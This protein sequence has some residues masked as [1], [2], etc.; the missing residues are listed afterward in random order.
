MAYPL[1]LTA[2]SAINL[3]TT[4]HLRAGATLW[5]FR[6]KGGSFFTKDFEV[7]NTVT[8]QLLQPH[9][10]YRVLDLDNDASMESAKEVCKAIV[11]LESTI[12]DIKITR[13]LI[14]GQYEPIGSD[15]DKLITDQQLNQ[16]N[17]SSWGQIIGRP[18]AFAP[19][20]HLHLDEQ[21]YGFGH[22]TYLIDEIKNLIGSQ[23]KQGFGTIYQYID[24]LFLEK[25]NDILNQL[26]GIELTINNV[27]VARRFEKGQIIMLYVSTH[28]AD[29]FGYGTWQQITNTFLYGV[30]IAAQLG[31]TFKIGSGVD[32]TATK[33]YFWWL[34]D[35]EDVIPPGGGGEE[36]VGN[37]LLMAT[38]ANTIP[39]N[40]LPILKK[41]SIWLGIIGYNA[42]SGIEFGRHSRAHYSDPYGVIPFQDLVYFQNSLSHP[43]QIDYSHLFKI[44]VSYTNSISPTLG[45]ILNKWK[46]NNFTNFVNVNQDIS[47]TFTHNPMHAH[48]LS[49]ISFNDLW[50]DEPIEKVVRTAVVIPTTICIN[51]KTAFAYLA[52]KGNQIY[53]SSPFDL[54]ALGTGINAE[55]FK[56]LYPSL[57]QCD[58]GNSYEYIICRIDNKWQLIKYRGVAETRDYRRYE[59]SNPNSATYL[60]SIKHSLGWFRI[61]RGM[62]PTDYSQSFI[63]YNGQTISVEKLQ[64]S[65]GNY[66]YRTN[67]G[68]KTPVNSFIAS[69]GMLNP[70]EYTYVKPALVR[71]SSTSPYN[72]EYD[73]VV[74]CATASAWSTTARFRVYID[75]NNTVWRTQ[76]RNQAH[77]LQVFPVI[78]R[79]DAGQNTNNYPMAEIDKSLDDL[80]GTKYNS[81]PEESDLY[82]TGTAPNRLFVPQRY[83]SQNSTVIDIF[84]DYYTPFWKSV[85]V[86]EKDDYLE[87]SVNITLPAV[88][89]RD[90]SFNFLLVDRVGKENLEYT[91]LDDTQFSYSILL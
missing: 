75:R 73:N 21:V 54:S 71:A 69:N 78:E 64:D 51:D 9:I 74:R 80:Y 82:G 72:V 56:T 87:F 70:E 13:R 48:E 88:A 12:S 52:M 76:Y 55:H 65:N 81:L 44:G 58:M 15:V 59:P 84:N 27:G 49:E 62:S 68:S 47:K 6:P 34:T 2:T 42:L 18:I 63:N 28:P 85:F 83:C 38:D 29:L 4:Q 16:L 61:H 41:D 66:R 10:H 22:V 53:I 19:D 89:T 90:Y 86:A 32:Y 79:R 25:Q 3:V 91:L 60:Y 31:Q 37:L 40:P 7:R 1:D 24:K 11:V 45:P 14:G 35:V 20:P 46:G 33:V 77:M 8:N 39:A 17:S 50:S 67:A 43:S 26:A 57:L 5:Y 23:A 30:D 36:P